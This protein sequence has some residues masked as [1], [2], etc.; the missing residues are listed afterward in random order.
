MSIRSKSWDESLAKKL[1]DKEFA[2]HYLLA[3]VN[4]E[5]LPLK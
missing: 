5:K 2:K 1:Q 3:L 4:D